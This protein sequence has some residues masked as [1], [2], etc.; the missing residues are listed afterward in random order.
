MPSMR[1]GSAVW[2][3]GATTIRPNRCRERNCSIFWRA[4]WRFGIDRSSASVCGKISGLAG[5]GLHTGVSA[6]SIT[7]KIGGKQYENTSCPDPDVPGLAVRMR[8]YRGQT[9]NVAAAGTKTT[10]SGHE[11]HA[12]ADDERLARSGSCRSREVVPVCWIPSGRC[13]LAHAAPKAWGGR[14]S[15]GI[16]DQRSVLCGSSARDASFFSASG[17]ASGRLA[18]GEGPVQVVP[19][20]PAGHVEGFADDEKPG[21]AGRFHGLG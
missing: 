2:K 13:P 7:K 20:Q 3:S 5:P 15:R 9:G 14:L 4:G 12:C 11:R 18:R 10:R 1:T 21:N 17:H 6:C 8:G 16:R 19:A